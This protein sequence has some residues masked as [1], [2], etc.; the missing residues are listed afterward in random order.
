MTRYLTPVVL[1]LAASSTSVAQDM[2]LAQILIDG[3]GWKKAEQPKPRA[4]NGPVATRSPDGSTTF[5]WVPA[6]RFIE[7]RQTQ[8]PGSQ[9]YIDYGPLRP[10]Y[11]ETTIEVTGLTTDRDGRI[12]AATE[13]GVQV[14]DP[15][16]RLCGVLTPA[17]P[18]KPK[19]LVFEGDQL[20]LWIGDTKY[21]RKLNTAG[22]K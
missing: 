9:P 5:R 6:G 1:V 10:K 18:G 12:Y 20:T 3:E 19:H 16:G 21:T 7:A 15:T 13:I 2:P 8:A 22:T 14:F 4:A 17:A 11:G